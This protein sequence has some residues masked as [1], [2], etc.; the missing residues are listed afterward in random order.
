MSVINTVSKLYQAACVLR[1]RFLINRRY[2]IFH[3][4]IAVLLFCCAH[5]AGAAILHVGAD[6]P[7]TPYTT[8]QAAVDAA[9]A[10]DEIWVEQGTYALT[11][12]I[13]VNKKVSIYGG[14]TGSETLRAERNWTTHVTTVDGQNTV[15]CFNTTADATIDGFTITRGYKN[16]GGGD[17][18]KGAGILNGDVTLLTP[19]A[20]APDLTVANCIFYRN[21]SFLKSGGAI[22]NYLSAGNL[23][24]NSCTFEENYGDE[25]GGAIRV[26]KGNVIIED[27]IFKN[28]KIKKDTGGVGGA[29]AISNTAG[30]A[31]ITRCTFTGNKCKDGGALGIDVQATITRCIFANT[32]PVIAAPR[33]GTIASRG[34]LP[35]TI[36]NC[37]FYGNRVQY[38]GGI[39][40]NSTGTNENLNVM[41]CTFSGNVLV[42]TTTGGGSI[43]SQKTAGTAF[44]VTNSILW[45][46]A[47]NKEIGG[48]T[49][50]LAPTVSYSDIDNNTVYAGNGNI[51]SDPLFAGSGDY[52]LQAASPCIDNGTSADA[53]STD[54]EGTSR[55]QGEG[56]DMGAYE[57]DPSAP[58]TTTTT[59]DTSTTTTITE[60]STT[61]STTT[62]PAVTTTMPASTSTTSSPTTINTTTSSMPATATT[63]STKT[64]HCPAWIIFENEPET[65][66]LLHRFRDKVLSTTPE[67]RRW[68]AFYYRNSDV[69]A[70]LLEHSPELQR[71]SRAALERLLPDIGLLVNGKEVDHRAM[72]RHARQL[73][74]LYKKDLSKNISGAS[75]T[76]MR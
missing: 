71:Q 48:A 61:S 14:F 72:R 56:F 7:G 55:P 65:L 30:T 63:T 6:W 70:G 28:N 10:D 12:M 27:S 40:I 19:P 18:E 46:N 32:N 17:D 37:L 35:L 29:V 67:G 43:Y 58:T 42:G 3:L 5:D 36:T 59:S 41:N 75:L 68:S 49:G 8:I 50:C 20:D 52:H 11:T 44:T 15:G 2:S 39:C 57:Y 64:K 38:G 45:G 76:L 60:S 21:E 51:K 74:D 73:I 33:Y 16:T 69:I 54:I 24:I 13:T 53:P 47:N 66:D 34:D 31:S 9:S 26:Q 23:T 1:S 4:L 22:C 25:Q 62:V